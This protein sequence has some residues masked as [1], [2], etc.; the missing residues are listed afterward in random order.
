MLYTFFD[1]VSFCSIL[2]GGTVGK[3]SPFQTGSRLKLFISSKN[4]ASELLRFWTRL[5]NV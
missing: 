3:N 5:E 2:R 4:M 1:D